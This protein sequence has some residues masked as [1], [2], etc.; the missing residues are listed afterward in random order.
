ME[1]KFKI[2]DRVKVIKINS[3]DFY[4]QATYEVGGIGAIARVEDDDDYD[5]VYYVKFDDESYNGNPNYPDHCWAVLEDWLE[6]YRYLIYC[7]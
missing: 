3:V 2:G 6:P 4:G 7:E 5:V 1:Y